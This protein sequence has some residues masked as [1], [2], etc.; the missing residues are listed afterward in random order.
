MSARWER[1]AKTRP[2]NTPKKDDKGP[3]QEN[4]GKNRF[5]PDAQ[6]FHG[7]KLFGPVGD[8]HINRIGQ[9]EDDQDRQNNQGDKEIT[10]IHPNDLHEKGGDFRKILHHQGEFTLA[11]LCF[12]Q[13][14]YPG[15][16]VV[17]IQKNNNIVIEF[18]EG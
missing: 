1:Y 15:Y 14:F 6:G 8:G 7:G 2:S 10:F 11:N 9:A 13:A 12:Q 18:P 17:R 3:F 5:I 4:Q 16:A